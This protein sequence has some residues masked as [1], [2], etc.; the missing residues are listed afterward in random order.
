M[1]TMGYLH[2]TGGSIRN[3]K[4][5]GPSGKNTRPMQGFLRKTLFDLMQ[6]DM[7]DRIVWDVFAGTG[8]IGIEALSRG[9]SQVYFIEKDPRMGAIIQ[10]NLT[11]CGFEKKCRVLIVDFF[12]IDTLLSR[13]DKPDIVFLDPPFFMNQ[14]EIIKKIYNF[15][16]LFIG[17][18]III[19]YPKFKDLLSVCSFYDIKMLRTYGESVLAFGSFREGFIDG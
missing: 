4:I 14:A 13:M 10:R 16:Q 7:S 3:R 15:K 18:L 17:S 1:M 11:L 5:I 9:A 8:A 12:Q 2:I 6:N 19:R